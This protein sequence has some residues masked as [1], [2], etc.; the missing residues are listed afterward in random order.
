MSNVILDELT[1]RER[2]KR[3][4]LLFDVPDNNNKVEDSNLISKLTAFYGNN[5]EVV[6]HFRLGPH[7]ATKKRPIKIIFKKQ[8]HVATFFKDIANLKKDPYF[9][10]FQFCNDYTNRQRD[11][12]KNLQIDLRAIKARDPNANVSIK[13]ID[14]NP[15]LITKQ[16]KN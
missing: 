10:S 5:I 4:I 9:S 16:S 7:T 3:N 12:L 15:K 14:G 13:H 6:A 8:E 1:D 2:R 11:H